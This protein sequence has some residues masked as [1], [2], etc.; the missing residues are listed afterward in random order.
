MGSRIV[1]KFTH[2]RMPVESAVHG[3]ALNAAAPAVNQ[4]YVG[5]S[6]PRG[7]VD[8]CLYDRGDIAR[9][10]GMQV[11]LPFNWNVEWVLIL[12]FRRLL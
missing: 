8:V 4:T 9:R 6:C 7:F 3:G 1:E 2:Q 12:H 10:K 5:E 11:E